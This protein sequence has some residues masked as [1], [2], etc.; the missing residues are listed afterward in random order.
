MLF[1][2]ALGT[3]GNGHVGEALEHLLKSRR[4]FLVARVITRGENDVSH[5]MR[6]LETLIA[7]L[8]R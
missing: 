4:I 1:D 2:I 6:Q 8:F 3:R 5:G 7:P